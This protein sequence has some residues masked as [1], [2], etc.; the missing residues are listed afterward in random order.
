MNKLS[1][2]AV[3]ALGVQLGMELRKTFTERLP[4]IAAV[5]ARIKE[6]ATQGIP[7]V[8]ITESE[9]EEADDDE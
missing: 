9:E 6:L 4:L 1:Q 7:V 8:W 5:Q 3:F 2:V